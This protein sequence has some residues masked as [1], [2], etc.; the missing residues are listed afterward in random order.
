MP[1]NLHQLFAYDKSWV[2]KLLTTTTTQIKVCRQTS[3]SP[4]LLTIFNVRLNL[5]LLNFKVE[6]EIIF[7]KST[8]VWKYAFTQFLI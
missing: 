8:K 3:V 7:R 5:K 2:H 4:Q 6:E 1:Q